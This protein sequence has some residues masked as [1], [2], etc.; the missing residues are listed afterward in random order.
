MSSRKRARTVATTPVTEPAPSKV[1]LSGGI[2]CPDN[3]IALW[4]QAQLL[5]CTIT[6]NNSDFQAHRT[7]LA[8]GSPFF[9]GAFTSGMAE[10]DSAHVTLPEVTASVFEAVLSFL[11]TG[12]AAVDEADLLPTLSA[13][14]F[15]QSAALIGAVT[16]RLEARLTPHNCLET[17]ALAETHGHESLAA[18]AKEAA[19]KNFEET[20]ASEAWVAATLQRVHALLTDQRLTTAGEEAV[21]NAVVRWVRAQHPRPDNAALLPLFRSVRYP[22]V[23]KAFFEAHVLTDPLLHRTALG[24]DVLSSVASVVFDPPVT[25][26]P[27]FGPSRPALTWSMTRKGPGAMIEPGGKVAKRV[28]SFNTVCSSE[29]LP[30]TGT[31]LVELIYDG[32]SRYNAANFHMTGILSAAAVE[33]NFANPDFLPDLDSGFWGVDVRGRGGGGG[34]LIIR[35]NGHKAKAP[36]EAN[37]PEGN[38][39]F[40]PGDRVGLLVDMDARTLTMLRNGEPIHESLVFDGLPNPI[41]VAATLAYSDGSQVRFVD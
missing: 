7:V 14:A 33:Q 25:R 32:A 13:A 24:Y 5:D 2:A 22:L 15:L 19:L 6:A 1:A 29:P 20:A 27:G 8:S 31:H 37:L 23:A 4:R 11:Y 17:L 3:M 36:A 10:S 18:A 41:Y 35:R 30:A 16:S 34:G 9:H 39:I 38:V 28:G 21:H 12:E 40:L 26:R